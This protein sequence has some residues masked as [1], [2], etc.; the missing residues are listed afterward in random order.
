[1]IWALREKLIF[2][3][4][5][6]LITEMDIHKMSL[7]Q[8]DLVK[9]LR[10]LEDFRANHLAHY[11]S[12]FPQLSTTSTKYKICIYQRM[13]LNDYIKELRAWLGIPRTRLRDGGGEF[14][15]H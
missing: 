1:M 2:D 12:Y 13:L 8:A 6:F 11:S 4:P 3:G 7:T 15:Y 5:V 10:K 9:R 14:S